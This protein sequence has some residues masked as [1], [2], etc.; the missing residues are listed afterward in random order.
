MLHMLCYRRGNTNSRCC[1][2]AVTSGSCPT[3]C[4]LFGPQPSTSSYFQPADSW[5][6]PPAVCRPVL[7]QRSPLPP[8]LWLQP[9]LWRPT[10]APSPLCKAVLGPLPRSDHHLGSHRNPS[11]TCPARLRD[12]GC[13]S[14]AMLMLTLQLGE[15]RL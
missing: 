15:P 5:A 11:S 12:G 2:P 14:P 1:C 13:S 10:P 8:H 4:S 9:G 6:L 7:G 3:S